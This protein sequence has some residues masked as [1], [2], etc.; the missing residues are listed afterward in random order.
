MTATNCTGNLFIISAPSGA[1]KSTLL[2][3][4]VDEDTCIAYSVSHT[5]R[6]PRV[7]EKHGEAYFFVDVDGFKKLIEQNAFL[8]WA[9]VH[10]NYYGTSRKPLMAELE[11]GRDVILD[12]DVVGAANVRARMPEA[13]SIFILP[14]DFQTLS[15]RL[16]ARAKDSEETIQRR[17]RNAASEIKDVDEYDYVLVNENLESCYAR[18]VEIVRA[19]RSRTVVNRHMIA[20]IVETF[21][22]SG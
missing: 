1:G 6:N 21:T 2:S 22:K 18:L 9:Q 8:E 5:T 13:V 12:I 14:P 3:R 20:K 16:Y 19:S 11:A 10:H 15:D 4:L 17:L 7:G